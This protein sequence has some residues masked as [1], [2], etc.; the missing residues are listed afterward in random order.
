M[1]RKEVIRIQALHFI[2]FI[3]LFFFFLLEVSSS[4]ITW[5]SHIFIDSNKIY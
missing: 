2:P 1:K 3:Y 5:D 4:F